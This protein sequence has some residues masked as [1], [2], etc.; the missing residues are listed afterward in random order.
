MK[1]HGLL[2]FHFCLFS[3]ETGLVNQASFSDYLFSWSYFG[4]KRKFAGSYISFS[5]SARMNT[6][7][8]AKQKKK[9][10]FNVTQEN[11]ISQCRVLWVFLLFHRRN[12]KKVSIW[13]KKN[14]RFHTVEYFEFFFYFIDSTEKNKSRFNVKKT[15]HFTLSSTLNFSIISSTEQK[16]RLSISHCRVLWA[17]SLFHWQSGEF[18]YQPATRSR[19]TWAVNSSQ[20]YLYPAEWW[21]SV[22]YN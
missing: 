20:L 2:F 14:I 11:Y 18:F 22:Y 7:D 3:S 17:F 10:V 6:L 8:C 21:V 4:R 1:I 19:V 15:A 16:K 12:R 13:R 5:V 9:W